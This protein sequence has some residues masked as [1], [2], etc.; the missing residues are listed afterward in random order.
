MAIDGAHCDLPAETGH[1]ADWK[2][3]R[4][5]AATIDRTPVPGLD[6]EHQQFVVP[7]LAQ[8][9]VVVDAVT[10]VAGGPG[11]AQRRADHRLGR[12]TIIE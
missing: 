3:P 10:P 7:R 12:Q 5:S 8:D 1:V 6:R 11:A 2:P 9:A 4:P